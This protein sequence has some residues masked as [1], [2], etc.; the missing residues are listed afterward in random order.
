MIEI[1]SRT[2]IEHKISSL[3]SMPIEERKYFWIG[4]HFQWFEVWSG[5]PEWGAKSIEPPKALWYNAVEHILYMDRVREYCG[6]GVRYSSGYRTPIWNTE[7]NGSTDSDH[8]YARAGDMV[9]LGRI[10]IKKFAMII[11]MLTPLDHYGVY[12]GWGSK[13]VHA[14]NNKDKQLLYKW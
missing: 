3:E 1:I 10:D 13:W 8:L 11:A 9:P 5:D 7:W 2:E 6:W 12:S 14:G 4:E